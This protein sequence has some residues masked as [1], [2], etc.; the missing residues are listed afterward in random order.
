VKDEMASAYKEREIAEDLAQACRVLGAY[1]MMHGATGHVSYRLDDDTMLIKGKG[2]DQVGLRYSRAR[3]IIK[4]NFDGDMVDGPD[5]LQPPSESFLHIWIYK[6]RPDVKSVV[7]AHPEYSVLLGI[8]GKEI[9]PAYGPY[10][11]GANLARDGVPIYPDSRTIQT[12]EQGESLAETMGNKDVVLMVGHGIAAAGNCIEQSSMNALALE[13]LCK[14]MYKAYLI[15]EPRRIPE[16][17][18]RPTSSGPRLRGSAG[19]EEGMR[20][21]WRYYVSRAEEM[22]GRRIN[23]DD[24]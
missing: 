7:H 4:V 12:N 24:D 18:F 15:G 5:G 3:D 10:R 20:A 1:D 6:M 8:T 17:E 14:T 22:L 19:G 11:P 21:S 13:T 16:S 23:L 9:V 2:P